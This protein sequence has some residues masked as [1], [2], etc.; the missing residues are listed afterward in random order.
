LKLL[1]QGFLFFRSA[2]R[3]H[4]VILEELFKYVEVPLGLS[5]FDVND[6]TRAFTL[7]RMGGEVPDLPHSV[8]LIT[9]IRGQFRRRFI[10]FIKE[11]A[12]LYACDIPEE[13]LETPTG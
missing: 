11:V 9:N 12:L 4:K 6:F 3:P 5:R 13:L 8:K 7:Y 1:V 2:R 10:D